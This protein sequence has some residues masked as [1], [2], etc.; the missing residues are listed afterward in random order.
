MAI[1]TWRQQYAICMRLAHNYLKAAVGSMIVAHNYLEAAVG[2]M[3]LAHNYLDIWVFFRTN[4]IVFYVTISKYHV[5][6]TTAGMFYNGAYRS[7]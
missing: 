2:N 3:K 4:E 6:Y 7:L 5:I 1:T